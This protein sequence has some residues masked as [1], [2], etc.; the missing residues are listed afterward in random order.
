MYDVNHVVAVN[1]VI[2]DRYV[3]YTVSSIIDNQVWVKSNGNW[4]NPECL[5]GCLNADGTPNNWDKAW[6]IER[7]EV[8][9]SV[10]LSPAPKLVS[11]DEETA[12]FRRVPAGNCACNIPRHQCRFHRD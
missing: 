9:S 5:F 1:D 2:T 4:K 10:S 12:F 7:P 6:T 3:S 8:V 11:L